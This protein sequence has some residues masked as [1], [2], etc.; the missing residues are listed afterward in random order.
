MDYKARVDQQ[1]GRRRMAVTGWI[2]YNAVFAMVLSLFQ[3]GA[4]VLFMQKP[5]VTMLPDEWEHI[6][7]FMYLATGAAVFFSA[8]VVM[9]TVPGL[10]R[11]EAWAW[12]VAVRVS[13]LMLL[14]GGGALYVMRDNPFAQLTLLFS[15]ALFVP[16]FWYRKSLD[17]RRAPGPVRI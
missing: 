13:A 12:D 8:W 10:R 15:L 6:F 2:Y 16:L 17:P 3:F 9:F 4:A 11:K 7:L 14:I 5:A 1:L